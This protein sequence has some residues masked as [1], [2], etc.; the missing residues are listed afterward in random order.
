MLDTSD[1][2]CRKNKRNMRTDITSLMVVFSVYSTWRM[3]FSLWSCI[4]TPPSLQEEV[5]NMKIEHGYCSVERRQHCSRGWVWNGDRP[6]RDDGQLESGHFRQVTGGMYLVVYRLPSELHVLMGILH[7]PNHF[8]QR[9]ASSEPTWLVDSGGL[10]LMSSWE[11]TMRSSPS[12][13]LCRAQ[14]TPRTTAHLFLFDG[15]TLFVT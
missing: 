9:I 5:W 10:L 7:E 3:G 11:L 15:D 6:S 1:I 12:S 8:R 14:L 4:H 13:E 2:I